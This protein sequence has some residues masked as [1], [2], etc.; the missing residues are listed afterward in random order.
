LIFIFT[1]ILCTVT[2][3]KKKRARACNISV[4]LCMYQSQQYLV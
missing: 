1:H 4:V 3:A 2:L